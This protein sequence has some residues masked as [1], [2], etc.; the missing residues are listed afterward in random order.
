M[1]TEDENVDLITKIVLVGDT[2]VG[3]TNL[4]HRYLRD[5]YDPET[6][7]TIGVD[8]FTKDLSIN[9]N[10]IKVQFFDTAGQEKYKSICSTYYKNADGVVLVYDVT[11]R[12]SFEGVQSWLDELYRYQAKDTKVLLV[13]N[14]ID[15]EAKR[16]VTADE[17]QA[18]ATE[19]KLYF[20]ETSAL[21]NKDRCVNRAFEILVKEI[22]DM[23]VRK[24]DEAERHE[25]E[26]IKKK[27]L[28]FNI[29]QSHMEV[30]DKD[31]AGKGCQ[32]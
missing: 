4:I 1:T 32:C 19:R 16:Q 11:N 27:S 5:L 26:Q 8:F 17:G 21:T 15:L 14:K 29:K 30:Y 6:K 18:Y 10:K 3:K 31:G 22:S 23:M 24:R 9:G 28:M 12:R 13:G 25:Y 2:A 7:A 20:M